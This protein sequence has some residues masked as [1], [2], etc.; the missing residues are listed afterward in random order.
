MH[1]PQPAP[2][3][4]D[5][6]DL[7]PADEPIGVDDT[8]LAAHA[9]GAWLNYEVINAANDHADAVELLRMRP[10]DSDVVDLA[11][12][13][14]AKAENARTTHEL[15]RAQGVVTAEAFSAVLVATRIAVVRT[16]QTL[17][18]AAGQHAAARHRYARAETIARARLS[19]ATNEHRRAQHRLRAVLAWAA[20]AFPGR[21]FGLA[22]ARTP[23]AGDSPRAH[24]Q[25][26]SGHR[27]GENWTPFNGTC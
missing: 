14:L 17:D 18:A 7:D 22:P 2:P 6:P 3:P 19:R 11:H 15:W 16:R 9:I 21:D 1:T 13:T 25:T 10:H 26:R 4:I 20:A 27:T 23:I 5:P 8:A 24:E 12:L